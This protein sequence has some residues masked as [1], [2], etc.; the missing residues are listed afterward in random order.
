MPPLNAMNHY[1]RS[2]SASSLNRTWTDDDLSYS[3]ASQSCPPSQLSIFRDESIGSYRE[4]NR[5]I[6]TR[7]PSL[8]VLA[9]KI[10]LRR[11]ST[12]NNQHTNAALAALQSP[13]TKSKKKADVARAQRMIERL[14]QAAMQ[15]KLSSTEV[16]TNGGRHRQHRLIR[17][18]AE[19]QLRLSQIDVARNFYQR[20]MTQTS[21]NAGP[22]P[23]EILKI[24]KSV[25]SPSL[26]RP[27]KVEVV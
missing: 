9:N 7:E 8:R 24:V 1:S 14:D 2:S 12:N 6:I 25:S 11:S 19:A 13:G 4:S 5:T 20:R 26:Q 21:A 16:S 17:Q 15:L 27:R 23:M 18:R 22:V 3:T 10:N